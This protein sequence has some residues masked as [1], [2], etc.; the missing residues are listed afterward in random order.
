[1]Y[2][3]IDVETTGLAPQKH[4]RVVEIA[5]IMLDEHGEAETEWSTLVN[6]DRDLGAQHIH[7][8]SAQD[9]LSA[10]RFEEI[11]GHLANSLKD[12]VV[13]AHNLAFDLL[14]LEAEFARMNVRFP[15][16]RAAGLCTMSL[17]ANWLPA[18]GRSLSDCCAT[19]GVLLSS[20]HSAL[21]DAHACA[22]LLRY[23]IAHAGQPPPWS[24]LTWE[25]R[26]CEWP[27]IPTHPFSPFYRQHHAEIKQPPSYV[28]GL[29]E[30][31]PRVDRPDLSEPYLAVLDQ[32]LSDRY[33][34]PDE[35]RALAALAWSLHLDASALRRLHMEYLDALARIALADQFLSEQERSDLAW[36][37]ETLELGADAV[38]SALQ[39]AAGTSPALPGNAL[40]LRP[41]EGVVFTG[42]MDHPRDYWFTLA[43]E[44]G[45][46]P[47]NTITKQT[48]LLV[49][50]DPWSLSG[51][52]KRARGYGIPI[53]SADEFR[54]ALI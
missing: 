20:P 50:A 18:S 9:V 19:A 52:A 36:V 48:R 46:T 38:A 34:S 32:A 26:M 42:E 54:R 7:G 53:V 31:M 16:T 6:P 14:F 45:F 35:S 11:A 40:P 44:H 21:G 39:R 3:A 17:A 43:T 8:I 4:H 49:A 33:L 13:V 30:F 28:A 51:K 27:P 23:Y 15:P 1:M 41:G 2:A 22:D 12:R 37:A 24:Q 10:P 29:I 5:V 25:C 47:M